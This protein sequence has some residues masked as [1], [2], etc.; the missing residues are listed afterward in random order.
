[1]KKQISLQKFSKR[2]SYS[3]MPSYG[4][5]SSNVVS[6]QWSTTTCCV[7]STFTKTTTMVV[8]ASVPPQ[9][10]N[11][12]NLPRGGNQETPLQ[13][14]NPPISNIFGLD[15]EVNIQ[16]GAHSYDTPPSV[17]ESSG[18]KPNGSLT[19]EKPTIDIVPW[20]PKGVL[21]KSKHNPNARETQKYSIVEDLAHAPCAMSP[22][23]YYKVFHLKEKHYCLQLAQST[24][25]ILVW[26]PLI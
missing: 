22:W 10:G 20:P 11:W 15:H 14:E 18:S 23:R 16:K 13:G 6:T 2:S 5:N 3:P 26:S 7:D 4:W 9:R 24:R 1:M 21:S 12:A 25:T 19:I 8:A 17:L